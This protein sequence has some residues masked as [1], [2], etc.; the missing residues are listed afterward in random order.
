MFGLGDSHISLAPAPAPA[1]SAKNGAAR[2][3]NMEE[4]LA[5]LGLPPEDGPAGP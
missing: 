2:A 4:Y 1:P 5:A 3:G